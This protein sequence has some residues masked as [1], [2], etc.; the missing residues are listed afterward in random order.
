[1]LRTISVRHQ[2][3]FESTSFFN[4]DS[5]AM[6]PKNEKSDTEINQG[7]FSKEGFN[8]LRDLKQTQL[9][10]IHNNLPQWVGGFYKSHVIFVG[11][12]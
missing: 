8:R 11:G 6:V 12:M 1:M 2:Q 5:Y 10:A 4:N 9:T 7:V 3:S